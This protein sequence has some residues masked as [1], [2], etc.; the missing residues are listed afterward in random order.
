[1]YDIVNV[2][3]NMT[4]NTDTGTRSKARHTIFA[5]SAYRPDGYNNESGYS[6]GS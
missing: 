5:V 6:A 1:M 4:S 2:V 3:G